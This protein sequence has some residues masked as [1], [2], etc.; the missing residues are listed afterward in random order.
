[1]R[2]LDDAADVGRLGKEE[3]KAEEK[4]DELYAAYANSE[5]G[6]LGTLMEYL[7]ICK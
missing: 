3:A 4:A 7:A 6:G 2:Q 5:Q 1:M